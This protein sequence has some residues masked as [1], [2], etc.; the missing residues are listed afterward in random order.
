MKIL[1]YFLILQIGLFLAFRMSFKALQE[2]K[3]QDWVSEDSV[4]DAHINQI[5]IYTWTFGV[6]SAVLLAMFTWWLG[7]EFLTQYQKFVVLKWAFSPVAVGFMVVYVVIF[8][9]P[10]IYRL[11]ND[12]DTRGEAMQHSILR[13]PTP[14]RVFW[15]CNGVALATAGLALLTILEFVH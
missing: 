1:C 10:K 9:C 6:S 7:T 12:K 13:Y 4:R 2:F 5:R 3:T 14:M 11:L 8:D 15:V